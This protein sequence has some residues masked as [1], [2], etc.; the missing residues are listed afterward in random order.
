MSLDMILLGFLR[1]P[2]SDYD[3]KKA[4][5]ES[6]RHFWEAELSQIYPTLHR[7]RREEWVTSTVEPSDR[8]PDRKVYRRTP[9]GV[10]AL[11]EWLSGAPLVEKQA[12]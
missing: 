7:L 9:A 5:D 10:A 11:R 1:S 3:L 4:F 8:G 12:Y 6:V 2:V